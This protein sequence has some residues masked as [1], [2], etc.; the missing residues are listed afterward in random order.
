MGRVYLAPTE[1]TPHDAYRAPAQYQC[2]H[3]HSERSEE[4]VFFRPWTVATSLRK[5]LRM[6]C[7]GSPPLCSLWLYKDRDG[8]EFGRCGEG[9]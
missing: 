2:P 5:I 7:G 9:D 1:P 3:C 8:L 4:S 6:E